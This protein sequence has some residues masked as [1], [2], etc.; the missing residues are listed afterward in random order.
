MTGPRSIG[1]LV[2]CFTLAFLAP[3]CT[4]ERRTEMDVD[5]A[6]LDDMSFHAYLANVPLVTVDEACRAMLILADGEDTSE[7]WEQR[8]DELLS[9]GIIRSAWDL[10][11]EHLINRGTVSF[12]VCKV[13]RIHGGVNMMLLGN[14]GIG[15]RR[16]AYRELV[17]RDML[18]AGSEWSFFTGGE[19]IALLTRADKLMEKKGLYEVETTRADAEVAEPSP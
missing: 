1:C 5:P 15:D 12:M 3:A 11:P 13:C 17:Y 8:R 14:L 4:H 19:L 6:Q 16:Y 7:S 2:G 9:R 10:D 18:P